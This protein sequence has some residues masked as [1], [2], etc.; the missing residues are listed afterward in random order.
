MCDSH[1]FVPSWRKLSLQVCLRSYQRIGLQG[2]G[3]ERF[4]TNLPE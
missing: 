2:Y 3:G 1:L 4:N